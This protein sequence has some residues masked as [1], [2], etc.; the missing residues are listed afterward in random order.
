MSPV[1]PRIVVH[2]QPPYAGSTFTITTSDHTIE[3]PYIDRVDLNEREHTPNWV[4]FHDMTAGGTL[5][6]TVRATPNKLWGAAAKDAPPS[7]S[8]A[9]ESPAEAERPGSRP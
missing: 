8:D 1:F 2:L 4:S 5:H 3:N 9:R 6:F 7:L